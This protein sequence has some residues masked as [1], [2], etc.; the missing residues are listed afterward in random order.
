M[1]QARRHRKRSA[2][3]VCSDEMVDVARAVWA[4]IPP[5]TKRRVCRWKTLPQAAVL[6]KVDTVYLFSFLDDLSDKGTQVT[7]GDVGE[8]TRKYLLVNR[9]LPPEAIPARLV[10]LNV[11]DESRIHLARIEDSETL[12]SYLLRF[13]Q[14]LGLDDMHN[15]IIDAWWEGDVLVV[16]SPGFER[17]RMPM[18]QL[19]K[20]LRRAR[21]TD[22]EEFTI[23]DFGEF[24]YWPKMDIHMGWSQFLQ[25]VDPHAKLRAQQKSEAF[26]HRYGLAIRDLRQDSEL[27]QSDIRGLDARTV[28]R[29]E[30]GERRA[31]ANALT[32]LANAHRMNANE[33]MA[34][35][36]DRLV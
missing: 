4:V 7:L 8:A 21:L 27:R 28:G 17:L 2:V 6:R 30:R 24:V 10:P 13:V 11:R 19:P 32:K 34:A 22:R 35:L 20:K 1:V 31:S 16:I 3:Y 12:E 9:S 25:A 18:P 26:N 5:R 15:A 36:A 14:A 33:Y 29:I 23:D